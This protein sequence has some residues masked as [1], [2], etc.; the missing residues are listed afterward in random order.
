MGWIE[1]AN[2]GF[3]QLWA[4]YKQQR[5][6]PRT[7]APLASSIDEAINAIAD[8]GAGSGCGELD[9]FEN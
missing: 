5:Q 6:Q 8:V 1:A 7:R 9:E 2:T 4:E 3:Q